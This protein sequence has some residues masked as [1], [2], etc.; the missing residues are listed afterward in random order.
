MQR[1]DSNK[2]SVNLENIRMSY[3][4]AQKIRSEIVEKCERGSKPRNISR[5]IMRALANDREDAAMRLH[6]TPGELATDYS[7]DPKQA[8]E[9]RRAQSMISD[10]PKKSMILRSVNTQ[11]GIYRGE[12]LT[13][14]KGHFIQ[15]VSSKSIMRHDKAHFPELEEIKPGN[16]VQINYSKGNGKIRTLEKSEELS[17]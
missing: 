10:Y 16:I 12:I 2:E 3:A 13:V 15:V 4:D 14:E 5:N 7:I 17:R 6:C 8:E 1:D 9:L 11:T